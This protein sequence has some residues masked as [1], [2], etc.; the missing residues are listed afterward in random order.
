M[1]V[2]YLGVIFQC[3]IESARKIEEHILKVTGLSIPPCILIPVAL[4]S[5]LELF[6][7]LQDMD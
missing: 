2:E 7:Q 1:A 6:G 4:S 5:G 3:S